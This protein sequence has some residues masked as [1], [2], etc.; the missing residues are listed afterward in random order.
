[1]ISTQPSI[2]RIGSAIAAVALAATATVGLDATEAGAATKQSC[3]NSSV[4][5][6]GASGDDNFLIA[7]QTARTGAADGFFVVELG[8]G[9]DTLDFTPGALAALGKTTRVC[10]RGGAG[11]DTINGTDGKDNLSGDAGNDVLIGFGGRD[12]LSG[13]AGKDDLFGGKDR[14]KLIGGPGSDFLYGAQGNDVLKPG[15]GNDTT[16]T[17]S[18]KNKVV[19][20]AG[21]DLIIAQPFVIDGTD[22]PLSFL[23]SSKPNTLT[24]GKGNDFIFGGSA[25]DKITGKAG[26]NWLLGRDGN[27]TLKGGSGNDTIFG[28]NGN[29]TINCGAGGEDWA[30]GGTTSYTPTSRAGES[31]SVAAPQANDKVKSSCELVFTKAVN[32]TLTGGSG[33]Q[34]ASVNP[35]SSMPAA[36]AAFTL[37]DITPDITPEQL[38]VRAGS[39]F[40]VA[41]VSQQ[42]D[43][44]G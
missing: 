20:K 38:L 44:R 19:N 41:E 11:N 27:D 42:P 39:E 15:G 23:G 7:E 24:G 33:S 13:G 1:M 9:D 30:G 43:A 14:D 28:G 12:T 31:I 21:T 26:A 16:I 8:A 3:K 36:A 22:G 4:D 37:P 5:L 17:G 29:D 25:A 2:R 10:V 35:E 34:S 6:V 18:G 40:R 32:I